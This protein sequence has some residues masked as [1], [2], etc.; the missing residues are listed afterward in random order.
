MGG[1]CVLTLLSNESPVSFQAF[2]MVF[3][4]LFK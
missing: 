2:V 4:F 3:S 1:V